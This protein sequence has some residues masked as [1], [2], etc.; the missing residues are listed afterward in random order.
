M[1]PLKFGNTAWVAATATLPVSPVKPNIFQSP[2]ENIPSPKI[3][4]N[5]FQ[6]I[7]QYTNTQIS[8]STL[9][10]VKQ[11]ESPGIWERMTNKNIPIVSQEEIT[12]WLQKARQFIIKQRDNEYVAKIWWYNIP[13]KKTLWYDMLLWWIG[14]LQWLDRSTTQQAEWLRWILWWK[15]KAEDI[16]NTLIWWIST[17]FTALFPWITAWFS[18]LWELP[19]TKQLLEWFNNMWTKWFTSDIAPKIPWLNLLPQ[20]QQAEIFNIWK[21][22]IAMLVLH[23]WWKFIKWYTTEMWLKWWVDATT[24][25]TATETLWWKPWEDLNSA[26]RRIS[27]KTHPDKPTGSNEAQQKV[28]EA[29]QYLKEKWFQEARQNISPEQKTMLWEMIKKVWEKIKNIEPNQK[30]FVWKLTDWKLPEKNIFWEM[31]NKEPVPIEPGKFSDFIP[32]AETK[33]PEKLT[34]DV[35][36]ADYISEM[37][38]TAPI[39]KSIEAKQPTQETKTSEQI[40]YEN[41]MMREAYIQDTKKVIDDY[42]REKNRI[43]E[44]VQRLEEYKKNNIRPS[45]KEKENIRYR[46]KILRENIAEL[47]NRND[48]EQNDQTYEDLMDYQVREKQTRWPREKIENVKVVGKPGNYFAVV[49]W[50][51]L[52]KAY[53][54]RQEAMDKW[55]IVLREA[56]VKRKLL[57]KWIWQKKTERVSIPMKEWDQMTD[58]EQ[59]IAMDKDREARRIIRQED[60]KAGEVKTRTPEEEKAFLKWMTVEEY[61]ASLPKAKKNLL[62]KKWEVNFPKL[63]KEKEIKNK[64]PQYP[65]VKVTAMEKLFPTLF[66]PWEKQSI[67]GEWV[68][69]WD[70]KAPDTKVTIAKDIKQWIQ[71][72]VVPLETQITNISK[73]I[74]RLYKNMEYDIKYLIKEYIKNS[75][76]ERTLLEKIKSSD[77]KSWDDLMVALY[78]RD[79]WKIREISQKYPGL[80]SA[81]ENIRK[82]VLKDA[83]MKS[84]EAW[85]N[86]H[87]LLAY[88]P[89]KVRDPLWLFN[90]LEKRVGTENRTLVQRAIAEREK[91]LDLPAWTLPMDEQIKIVNSMMR[92]Y[93]NE[94]IGMWSPHFRNRSLQYMDKEIAQFYYDPLDSLLLYIKNVPEAIY[95]KKL[96]WWDNKDL[97]TIE[98]SIGAEIIKLWKQN[99][100]PI[101]DQQRLKE[102]ILMRLSH[103]WTSKLVSAIKNITYWLTLTNP[104]STLTQMWDLSFSLYE[105]WPKMTWKAMISPKNVKMEDIWILDMNIEMTDNKFMWNYLNKMLKSVWFTSMDRFGKEV[106]INSTLNKLTWWAKNDP[107][108]LMAEL[109]DRGI[110][111]R[112]QDITL[113]LRE[114][115]KVI[116][117][118]LWQKDANKLITNLLDK[119]INRMLWDNVAKYQPIHEWRMPPTYLTAKWWTRLIYQLKTFNITSLDG[120]LGEWRKEFKKSIELEPQIKSFEEKIRIIDD[121]IEKAK[122]EKKLDE[123][124]KQKYQNYLRW[125]KNMMKLVILMTVMWYGVK[126]IKDFI[127]WKNTSPL[128]LLADSFLSIFWTSTYDFSWQWSFGNSTVTDFINKQMMPWAVSIADRTFQSLKYIITELAKWN[129][130][131]AKKISLFRNMPLAWD[132][133]YQRMNV[134]SNSWGWGSTWTTKKSLWFT[135][136]S[137]GWFAK[138]NVWWFAKKNVWWFAK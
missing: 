48:A 15:P 93:Y 71:N 2:I 98:N 7:P 88:R 42:T 101:E 46:E 6:Q 56:E 36:L 49:E 61:R 26:Y 12:S 99:N 77:K 91:K 117:S 51:Q 60:R 69:K 33:V 92:W 122:I 73:P 129:I 25:K 89:F 37:E 110:A 80:E 103:K 19:W 136:N 8:S 28:N 79:M 108:R 3:N 24:Y 50:K 58:F 30:W 83:Y 125:V 10:P 27:Q 62:K 31:I 39:E 57:E 82:Y 120:I 1:V 90:F 123:Q 109:E 54:T 13:N 128:K 135:K 43:A 41:K 22:L 114:I 107:A 75:E 74:W 72:M 59:Q 134:K 9:P 63:P 111:D 104:L 127:K 21:N 96:F 20:E 32:S 106:M 85:Y 68:Y 133:L 16:W 78:N 70:I 52:P 18:A 124:K 14:M 17:A 97:T 87:E 34:E 38:K 44:R 126:Q 4:T 131:E 53:I 40:D 132:L 138:S 86:Y 29:Y 105:N 115:D 102:L 76:T 137:V 116:Q 100:I 121:P 55:T 84:K 119:N 95:V 47:N 112:F 67:T 35:K 66:F 130:P 113:R 65:M 5:I 45:E 94:N 118:K 11:V 23:Y 81:I 64:W